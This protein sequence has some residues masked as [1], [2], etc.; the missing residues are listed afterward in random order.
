MR[1]VVI[2]KRPDGTTVTHVHRPFQS[3]VTI[4]EPEATE[5]VVV[6]KTAPPAVKVEARGRAPSAKHV[7]VA[8]RWAHRGGRWVWKPG[9][10]A[11]RPRAKAVWVGGHWKR[12]GSG[13]KWVPGHWR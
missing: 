9:H 7:W 8:G 6:V 2:T 12:T 10:W 13:W 3:D 4:V 11:A 5:E 1:R